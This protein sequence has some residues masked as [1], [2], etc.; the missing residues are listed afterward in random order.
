[1]YIFLAFLSD[2]FKEELVNGK[3]FYIQVSTSQI[4][5]TQVFQRIIISNHSHNTGHHPQATP[6]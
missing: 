6:T 3:D 2:N 5:T 1:M 4:S